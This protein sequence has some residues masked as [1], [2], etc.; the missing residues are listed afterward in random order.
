MAAGGVAQHDR[1]ARLAGEPPVAPGDHGRQDGVEVAA[2]VGEDVLVAVGLLLVADPRQHALL[3][4]ALEPL[5]EDVA[6][7][8][9]RPLHVVEAAHPEE[10]LPE[11]ERRPPV[12]QQVDAAGD[13]TRP[14]GELRPL[15]EDQ[16]NSCANEPTRVR[17]SSL[18]QLRDP[19]AVRALPRVPRETV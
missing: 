17:V 12:A 10:G 15:H 13:G 9:Q 5:G 6:A 11:H 16:I 8:P 14:R 3:D 19:R 2:L 1:R 7:D 4:E 18:V